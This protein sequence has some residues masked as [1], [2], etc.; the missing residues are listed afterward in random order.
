M[1]QQT[2]AMAA[3]QGSGFEHYRKPTRRDEFLRIYDERFLRMWEFYLA[4]FEPYFRQ[5]MFGV[6][7]IQ[8]QKKDSAVPI[9]RDYMYGDS[10]PGVR[11]A[12]AAE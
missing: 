5:Y 8:L 3:D 10:H 11:L 12:E 6:F 7:Q 1:K 2:L 9:T 4:A